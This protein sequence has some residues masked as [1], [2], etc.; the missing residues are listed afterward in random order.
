MVGMARVS[1]RKVLRSIILSIPILLW[2]YVVRAMTWF[3]RTRVIVEKKGGL[4]E[5]DKPAVF[6]PYLSSQSA[7]S[8]SVEE[9]ACKA[10]AKF[11]D[12]TDSCR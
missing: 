11:Y 7:C 1:I 10:L 3:T 4:C 9:E 12:R 5:P 8:L 6:D 2:R